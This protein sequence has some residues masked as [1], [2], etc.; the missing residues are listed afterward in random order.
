MANIYVTIRKIN[1][2]QL[3]ILLKLRYTQKKIFIDHHNYSHYNTYFR[4]NNELQDT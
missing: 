3:N 2:T 4:M 1:S